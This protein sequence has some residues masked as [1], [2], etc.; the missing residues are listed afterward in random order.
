MLWLMCWIHTTPGFAGAIES[1]LRIASFNIQILGEAKI[2]KSEVTQ[3]RVKILNRYDVQ[4]AMTEKNL[5]F[6]HFPVEFKL[7][8]NTQVNKKMPDGYRKFGQE[9]QNEFIFDSILFLA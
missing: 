1:P 4:L 2:D 7:N 6:D 3:T 8:V 9:F 5:V